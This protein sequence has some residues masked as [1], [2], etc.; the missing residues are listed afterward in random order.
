MRI[1]RAG[2]NESE[3]HLARGAEH[4]GGNTCAYCTGCSVFRAGTVTRHG[5]W[6]L[7]VRSRAC[8]LGAR[9][10]SRRADGFCGENRGACRKKG[11]TT[12]TTTA[13]EVRARFSPASSRFSAL[14]LKRLTTTATARRATNEPY[15]IGETPNSLRGTYPLALSSCVRG[16]F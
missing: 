7:T 5:G 15:T 12:T 10:K 2:L 1:V 4:R 3:I 16:L 13:A 14:E 11:R 6:S 8:S 9:I